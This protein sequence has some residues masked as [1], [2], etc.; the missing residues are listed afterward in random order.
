[1]SNDGKQ[2]SLRGSGKVVSIE[3]NTDWGVGVTVEIVMGNR[4]KTRIV[5]GVIEPSYYDL[6]LGTE[7][8][9][10]LTWPKRGE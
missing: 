1:M 7:I 8:A 9:V 5:L 2:H 6:S 4:D 10:E 3:P